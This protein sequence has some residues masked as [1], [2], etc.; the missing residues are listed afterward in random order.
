MK[1]G[2]IISIYI[3]AFLAADLYSSVFTNIKIR[4]IS[5]DITNHVIMWTNITAAS[6][7]WIVADQYVQVNYWTNHTIVTGWGLQI[8]THNRTNVAIPR[9]KGLSNAN[10]LVDMTYSNY[11]LPMA[12]LIKTNKS[13]PP[14]PTERFDYTGFD[15]YDWHYLTDK[16]TRGF[17]NE[18]DYFV[19]W[20]QGG[21]A[22]HEAYRQQKPFKGYLYFAAKF[23]NLLISR[24]QTSQLRV[25][26][27]VNNQA[28]FIN[29][30][31]IF[32][33]AWITPVPNH[34]T[35]EYENWGAGGA[36]FANYN[37]TSDYHSPGGSIRF[38]LGPNCQGAY[39]WFE[40]YPWAPIGQNYGYDLTGAKRLT[41]WVKGSNTYT[42]IIYAQIGGTGE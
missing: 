9:F 36:P 13:R 15:T 38:W 6:Q 20:N 26:E 19:P 40:P 11:L 42:G 32:T 30:F 2:L 7:N 33:N 3:L 27:Y 34:Y 39:V 8:Y 5:D 18:K 28:K 35:P 17:T 29:S 41:F 37:Y 4:N 10:S 14:R 22:W 1:K 16:S 21:I 25:E 23:E 24:Y 31:W 12:W